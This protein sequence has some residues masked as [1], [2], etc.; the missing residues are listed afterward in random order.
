MQQ[1][2]SEIKYQK[3]SYDKVQWYIILRKVVRIIMLHDQHASKHHEGGKAN[4]EAKEN[5]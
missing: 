1:Q 5:L 3:D 4:D 2:A